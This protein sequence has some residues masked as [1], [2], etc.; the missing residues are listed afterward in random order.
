MTN[1]LVALFAY[2]PFLAFSAENNTENHNKNALKSLT[3]DAFAH[4]FET[5]DANKDGIVLKDE[6]IS[7]DFK[8]LLKHDANQNGK[9][10]AGEYFNAESERLEKLLPQ[11]PK[12][13]KALKEANKQAIASVYD[14]FDED[15]DNELSADE[16]KILSAIAFAQ[17]DANNDG[18]IDQKDLEITLEKIE[19]EQNP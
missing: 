5:H 17:H 11:S 18:Q 9:I 14:D 19:I 7:E 4:I 13:N 1:K 8:I 15:K 6:Y 16:L 12:A 2:L 10:S 3:G